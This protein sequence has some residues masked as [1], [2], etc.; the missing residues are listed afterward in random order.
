M[1]RLLLISLL[2]NFGTSYASLRSDLLDRPFDRVIEKSIGLGKQYGQQTGGIL[3]FSEGSVVLGTGV[4]IDPWTVVTA[5]HL[6]NLE[7][8]YI[9]VPKRFRTI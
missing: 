3:I 9:V 2:L 6:K 4:L 8:E 1:R 7:K 5:A